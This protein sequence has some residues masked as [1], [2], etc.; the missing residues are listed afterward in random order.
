MRQQIN[1]LWEQNIN[2]WPQYHMRGS[3]FMVCLIQWKNMNVYMCH[4]ETNVKESL[5]IIVC[6]VMSDLS[7]RVMTT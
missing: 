2:L 6:A 4:H 5:H 3:V 7:T 1:K